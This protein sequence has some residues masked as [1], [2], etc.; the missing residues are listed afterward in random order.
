MW[1]SVAIPWCRWLRAVGLP[2]AH[3][4]ILLNL[5]PVE[6]DSHL[7][8][9]SFGSPVFPAKYI[10]KRGDPSVRPVTDDTANKIRRLIELDYDVDR[11]AEILCLQVPMVV[12]C[13][14]RFTPVRRVAL[15]RPRTR[16]EQERLQR[17][18]RRRAKAAAVRAARALW[19]RCASPLD[20]AGCKAAIIP[21]ADE[22]LDLAFE[23]APLPCPEPTRWNQTTDER[24][25]W[26]ES[27]GQA[28]LTRELAREIR[29]LHAD[30][31]SMYELARRFDV[32][33]GTIAA[34][35]KGRT[36]LEPPVDD[37]Q[38]DVAPAADDVDD[39]ADVTKEKRRRWRQSAQTPKFGARGSEALHDDDG[40]EPVP[41]IDKAQ[42]TRDQI[43][44]DP[45]SIKWT[46]MPGDAAD[47]IADDL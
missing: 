44:A 42:L 33:R 18:Q 4:A 17:N 41:M 2:T 15:V 6:V 24:T 25:R 22:L 10:G 39:Q 26:G 9:P 40:S 35:V 8:V 30:G 31:V 14:R 13:L 34:I 11:I 37:D 46:A 29:Q 16:K 27:N 20:D 38:A 5:D 28:K 36:W 23:P 3:I 47:D 1:P 12:N 19:V 45:A 43:G 21:S 32:A 7:A